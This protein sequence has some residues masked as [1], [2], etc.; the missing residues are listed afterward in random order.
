MFRLKFDKFESIFN[1][2][3]V[4]VFQD[5]TPDRKKNMKKITLIFIILFCASCENKQKLD[6]FGDAKIGMSSREFNLEF[7]NSKLDTTDLLATKY[8]DS[9]K[10]SDGIILKNVH[11]QFE[12]GKLYF[13]SAN[14][15]KN[16]F[17]YLRNKYGIERQTK[18]DDIN[19]IVFN[20][21]SQNLKCSYE[22][23]GNNSGIGLYDV[24]VIN[25]N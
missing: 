11:V 8:I 14:Y 23:V 10:I 13:I 15:N 24:N 3:M 18:H 1:L 21:N 6:G 20:T 16:L 25:Q 17:E 12:N 2:K 7:P 22:S 4:N 19:L 9:L 5:K